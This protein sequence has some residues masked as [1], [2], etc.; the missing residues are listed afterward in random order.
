MKLLS[1]ITKL[2]SGRAV[3]LM[4]HRIA[5]PAHDHWQLSV[6]PQNFEAHLQVLKQYNVFDLATLVTQVPNNGIAISFDDG[7]IDNYTIAKPLLEKYHLPATFFITNGSLGKQTEF[8][9]DELEHIFSND[10]EKHLQVWAQ[11]LP[12]TS[13]QQQKELTTIRTHPPRPEYRCM[14]IE[15]LKEMAQNP[16]FSI[17]AHTVNHV[18]LAHQQVEVQREEIMNNAVWLNEVIG[19]MPRLLAYPYGKYNE[20]SIN[21]ARE[22]GFDAAFT[23]DAQPITKNS[24]RYQLGRFQMKNW[25]ASEFEQHLPSWL[26]M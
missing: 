17:G 15:Q 14:N 19:K 20:A 9:W 23:T 2:F 21:I 16:L 18:S 24:G 25:N 8:W 6:S 4:Y 13:E 1:K 12:L 3:V 26:K 11:L 22:Q 10:E 7:Y 5:T